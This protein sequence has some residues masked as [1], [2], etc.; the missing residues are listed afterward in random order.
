MVS[1]AKKP[2]L[3]KKLSAMLAEK[4]WEKPT[5]KFAV[6]SMLE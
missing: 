1:A 2:I 6:M 3:L 4:C 5:P